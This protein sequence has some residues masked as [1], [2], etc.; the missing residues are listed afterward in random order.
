MLSRAA[1]KLRR[2]GHDRSSWPCYHAG[3]CEAGLRAEGDDVRYRLYLTDASGHRREILIE[4][5]NDAQ[6]IE[7]AKRYK[8]SHMVEV[9]QGE[10]RIGRVE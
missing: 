9:W 8:D 4:R 7:Q 5:K 10:R 3:P 6:A 1:G 2:V